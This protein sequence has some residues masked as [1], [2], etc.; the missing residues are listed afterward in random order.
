MFETDEG[1]NLEL[2]VDITSA[3]VERNV[4]L[5]LTTID[6]TAQGSTLCMKFFFTAVLIQN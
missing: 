4:I 3:S 1:T 2:C 6:A 5:S